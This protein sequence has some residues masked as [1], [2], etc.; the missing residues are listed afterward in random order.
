MSA[1]DATSNRIYGEYP[2]YSCLI[3]P[4]IPAV[5]TLRGPENSIWI[6]RNWEFRP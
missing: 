2:F 4:I 6:K 1:L 5:Y 3:Y